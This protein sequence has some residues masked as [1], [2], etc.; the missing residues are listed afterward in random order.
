MTLAASATHRTKVDIDDSQAMFQLRWFEEVD[1]AGEPLPQY[2]NTACRGFRLPVTN[3]GYAFEWTSNHQVACPVTLKRDDDGARVLWTLRRNEKATIKA[4][5]AEL[6]PAGPAPAKKAKPSGGASAAPSKAPRNPAPLR[7]APAVAPVAA[8]PVHLV[9][10]ILSGVRL[11]L[12]ATL[13]D[14]PKEFNGASVDAGEQVEILASQSVDGVAF[15][16]VKIGKKRG[17]VNAA[18]ISVI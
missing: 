16:H 12:R 17:F 11:R 3:G 1:A 6:K 8:P 13:S 14:A 18:Y 9:G 7:T 5:V 2:G 10:T 4:K 15:H